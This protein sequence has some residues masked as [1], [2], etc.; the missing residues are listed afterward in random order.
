M[1]LLEASEAMFAKCRNQYHP[2]K[3][4]GYL[5]FKLLVLHMIFLWDDDKL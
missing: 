3:T 1:A 2:L 4:E 5:F